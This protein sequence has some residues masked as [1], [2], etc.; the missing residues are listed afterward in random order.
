MINVDCIYWKHIYH[1]TLCQRHLIIRPD[2]K[3]SIKSNEV[4]PASDIKVSDILSNRFLWL[5][6]P[7]GY[8]RIKVFDSVQTMRVYIKEICI[9]RALFAHQNQK[10]YMYFVLIISVFCA[11]IPMELGCYFQYDQNYIEQELWHKYDVLLSFSIFL[12]KIVLFHAV[13][14]NIEHRFGQ[15]WAKFSFISYTV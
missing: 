4:L 13:I 1:L 8:I 12:H 15:N 10:L 11:R 7:V 6:R 2:R 3:I 9:I 5:P 14:E